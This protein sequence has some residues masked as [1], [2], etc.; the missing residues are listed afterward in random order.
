MSVGTPDLIGDDEKKKKERH[1]YSFCTQVKHSDSWLFLEERKRGTRTIR[2]RRISM[3]DYLHVRRTKRTKGSVALRTY[4][5]VIDA[6]VLF[7]V[8]TA[9][10]VRFGAVHGRTASI[11]SGRLYL[12]KKY[13]TAIM[14][15]AWTSESPLLIVESFNFRK[16]LFDPSYN[17]CWVVSR[18]MQNC[19]MH[20][21][22]KRASPTKD[23][24]EMTVR[25]TLSLLGVLCVVMTLR[26]LSLSWHDLQSKGKESVQAEYFIIRVYG[27]TWM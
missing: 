7:T 1:Y 16:K 2:D 10:H 20:T 19:G 5:E 4:D 3:R 6:I 23:S 14:R 21:V 12:C 22:R 18:W 11:E 9:A 13:S 15:Q 8:V 27:H 26:Q 25:H 24:I 17:F